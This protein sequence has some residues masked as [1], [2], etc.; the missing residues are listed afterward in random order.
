MSQM[1]CL[2]RDWN[3]MLCDANKELKSGYGPEVVATDL[4]QE[5]NTIRARLH[6]ARDVRAQLEEKVLSLTEAVGLLQ[7]ELKAE[8]MTVVTEYKASREFESS[9]EKMGWVSYEFGY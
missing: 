4:K 5:V 8:G 1:I 2:M 9:L 6:E 7:S 3:T